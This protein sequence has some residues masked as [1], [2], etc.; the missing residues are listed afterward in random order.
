MAADSG[1]NFKVSGCQYIYNLGTSGLGTGA[2]RVDISIA[3]SVV[4]RLRSQ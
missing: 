1:T 3:G 4:N 2:Y